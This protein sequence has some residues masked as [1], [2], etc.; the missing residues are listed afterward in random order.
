MLPPLGNRQ[1]NPR[2]A[3]AEQQQRRTPRY[4]SP[5]LSLLSSSRASSRASHASHADYRNGR[6][7]RVTSSRASSYHS[8]DDEVWNVNRTPAPASEVS[9]NM[10]ESPPNIDNDNNNHNDNHNHNH[11]HKQ[12]E[13]HYSPRPPSF[14]SQPLP[15]QHQKHQLHFS[16]NQQ[17]GGGGDGEMYGTT[18][19]R[20]APYKRRMREQQRQRRLDE[21]MQQYLEK[22]Q[23]K[24]QQKEIAN[25]EREIEKQHFVQTKEMEF[26]E[27]EK[28]MKRNRKKGKVGDGA[29]LLR[30]LRDRHKIAGNMNEV[31]QFNSLLYQTEKKSAPWEKNDSM[32]RQGSPRLR[33]PVKVVLIPYL[34]D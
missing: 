24:Q 7:L 16:I 12:S 33:R 20:P 9:Y 21:R 4:R 13:S 34:R 28:Q 6:R 2:Q 3:V 10:E 32:T 8:V 22:R 17:D 11:N 15:P 14:S 1:R 23:V 26:H 19:M 29:G 25:L 31:E 5:R 27:R 30:L 18:T